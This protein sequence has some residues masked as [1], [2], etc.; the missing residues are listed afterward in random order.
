MIDIKTSYNVK[1]LMR[2]TLN[3]Q[4]RMRKDIDRIYIFPVNPFTYQE[5]NKRIYIKPA[6][7]IVLAL[8]NGEKTIL[9]VTDDLIGILNISLDTASRIVT[10]IVQRYQDYLV[11]VDQVYDAIIQYNPTD[12]II[13]KE[14]IDTYTLFPKIPEIIMFIP[15]FKCNFNCRY[16]YAPRNKSH[17]ILHLDR[18]ALMLKQLN[19]WHIPSIFFSGGDPFCHPFIN[20]VLE[21]CVDNDIKPILPTKS[22]INIEQIA[23]LLK[24][25]V[26]EIQISIDAVQE[27]QCSALLG[28]SGNYVHSQ[29]QHIKHLIANGI[30][31]YTNSVLTSQTIRNIP[32]FVQSLY[33]LGV[34]RMSFS[35]YSRSLF[36][37]QDDM[38]C[39]P[40]DYDWLDHEIKLLKRRLPELKLSYKNMKDPTFMT[41]QEKEIYFQNRPNCTAGKM[42]MVILPNGKVTVCETLYH[43]KNLILGDLQDSSIKDIW[44]SEQRKK[45]ITQS[46]QCLSAGVC[47]SCP[48]IE[49]CYLIKGKC[50]VR[51]L[52]AF[53]DVKMPDPYCPKSP[54][55]LRI[56]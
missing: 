51:A 26:D 3:P 2:V 20:D 40:A 23:Y 46:P 31:V 55:G 21:L 43:N 24:I 56:L 13:H 27:Q 39:S 47:K 19:R 44:N 52:Q 36:C 22:I 6:E 30:R 42:G 9:N 28:S 5:K 29:L 49:Y 32:V 25:G 38:F 15:T 45:I 10:N 33:D 41:L 35:Q 37:H 12:F 54:E 48:E 34:R 53:N 50:Y 18:I 16:C 8:F 4:L 1:P 14:H 17:Y 7:A 11:N